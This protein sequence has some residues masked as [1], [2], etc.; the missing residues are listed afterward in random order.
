MRWRRPHR[1]W[2]NAVLDADARAAQRAHEMRV[3]EVLSPPHAHILRWWRRLMH[4]A[5]NASA[6]RLASTDTTE[7]DG[8]EAGPATLG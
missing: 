7:L 1:H 8:G 5:E 6:Q 4:E 2:G 3:A